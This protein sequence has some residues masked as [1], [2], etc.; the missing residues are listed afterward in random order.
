MEAAITLITFAP[1]AVSALCA[2]YVGV[3]VAVI[4]L[5]I[6]ISISVGMCLVHA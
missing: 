5:A 2:L 6:I 4:A 3:P 1:A